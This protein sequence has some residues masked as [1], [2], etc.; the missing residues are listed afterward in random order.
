M[1]LIG[2]FP[3]FWPA[4]KLCCGRFRRIATLRCN[5]QGIFPTG[6]VDLGMGTH[7]V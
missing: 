6:D 7:H 2:N 5:S 1:N 4:S 3:T